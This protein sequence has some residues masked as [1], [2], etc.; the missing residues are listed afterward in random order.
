[1][2]KYSAPSLMES[3]DDAIRYVEELLPEHYDLECISGRDVLEND[4]FTLITIVFNEKY[5]LS[6]FL[7][8]Y[9]QLGVARFL[10]IDDGS[11]DGSLDY[12]K[13]QADIAVFQSTRYRYGDYLPKCTFDEG[14]K[15]LRVQY[16]WKTALMRNYC[17]NRWA[18]VADV[19]EF[20]LLPKG[21]D[22]P[23]ICNRLEGAGQL[24]AATPMIDV[25]P[26]TLQDLGAREVFCLSDTW[27]HDAV[28]HV[29]TGKSGGVRFP[30]PGARAR[31][32]HQNEIREDVKPLKLRRRLS[33]LLVHNPPRYKRFNNIA[34]YSLIKWNSHNA[35]F[36]SHR[37]I[38]TDTDKVYTALPLLHFKF[39]H[40]IFEKT[41][42]ALERRQYWSGSSE[43]DI[44]EKLLIKMHQ[45]G[46]KF[47]F[48][49]SRAGMTFEALHKEQ[50][51][52]WTL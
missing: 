10:I 4:G 32:I 37:I 47:T 22:L 31:L 3:S 27:Y 6:E 51:A 12:C 28:T 35:I 9:R 15:Q 19:D 23:E 8:H 42:N 14:M 16:M 17:L 25:Y 46:K 29:T 38:G 5:F 36:N 44:L 52:L 43:Y 1:M 48:A 13:A 18:M 7:R 24:I 33:N 21:T 39:S 41:R 30:Y 40:S 34:K 11:T 26:K 50:I 45:N 2:K 49:R 20:L